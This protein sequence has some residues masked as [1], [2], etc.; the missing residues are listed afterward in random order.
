MTNPNQMRRNKIT[1]SLSIHTKDENQ[2]SD[3]IEHKTANYNSFRRL[4]TLLLSQHN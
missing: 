3:L 2:T 1:S 4:C